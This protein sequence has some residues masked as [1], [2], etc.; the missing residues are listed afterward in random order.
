M[1]RDREDAGH[2][3]ARELRRYAGKNPLVL[4]VPRGAVPMAK[5]IAD[6]LGGELDVVLVHKLGAPGN[7]EYAIGAVGEDGEVLLRRDHGIEELPAAYVTEERER[8]LRVLR[9]R[10]ARYTP[11]R[12]AAD[13][14]GRVV[15]LVD[16]GIA[17][18]AT[19][20]AALQSVRAKGPARLV[21]AVAVAPQDS[22]VAIREV[23]DE[24]IC[25]ATPRLFFAVGQFFADFRQV[26]DDDVIEALRASR[27]QPAPPSFTGGKR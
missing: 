20:Q 14:S 25:L 17:T 26:E 3:L 27:R 21:A 23:A 18:G 7:P 5:V 12:P 8:Q 1:F 6:E 24:V 15:V 11:D 13:P 16:D 9:A 10:R 4:A 2:R 22:L 19:L